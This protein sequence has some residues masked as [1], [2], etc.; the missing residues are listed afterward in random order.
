M[1]SV[2]VA[3]RFAPIVMRDGQ[4]IEHSHERGAADAGAGPPGRL[5]AAA[6]FAAASLPL[7]WL[8]LRYPQPQL[9]V[10][11][12]IQLARLPMAAAVTAYGIGVRAL[13]RWGAAMV[14]DPRDL[15]AELSHTVGR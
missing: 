1:P 11:G 13:I 3:A 8:R 7:L 15:T 9:T 12:H 14:L 10:S 5:R 4:P 2:P 6:V